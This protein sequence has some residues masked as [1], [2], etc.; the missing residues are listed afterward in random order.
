MNTNPENPIVADAPAILTCPNCRQNVP[1]NASF[2]LDC[3]FALRSQ[4]NATL[5]YTRLLEDAIKPYQ[6][7]GFKILQQS[8]MSITMGL[9]K[10]MDGCL[11]VVLLL[12]FFPGAIL[13]AIMSNRNAYET[14]HFRVTSQGTVEISGYKLRT[15][16]EKQAEQKNQ[17]VAI[18][19]IGTIFIILI[20][21]GWLA[22]FGIP[23]VLSFFLLCGLAIAAVYVLDKKEIFTLRPKKE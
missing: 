18:G 19:L 21:A 6:L 12:V 15:K 4:N 23:F 22:S 10:Q 14:A 17:Y 7:R 11:F 9:P 5:A 1:S 13:Y 8:E 20:L 3:G 2:C 16:A